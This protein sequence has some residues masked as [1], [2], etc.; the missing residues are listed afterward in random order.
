MN[1][2]SQA[3]PLA[4]LCSVSQAVPEDFSWWDGCI[5]L[6]LQ[7]CLGGWC[8]T[9]HPRFPSKAVHFTDNI[10]VFP[11]SVVA[12]HVCF[13]ISYHSVQIQPCLSKLHSCFWQ[14]GWLHLI[15]TFRFCNY[16]SFLLNLKQF[17]CYCAIFPYWLLPSCYAFFT[18][19]K[20]EMHTISA[21]KRDKK[22]PTN[23]Y[24]CLTEIK[25]TIKHDWHCTYNPYH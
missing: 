1:F 17:S 9:E 7:Q 10:N 20:A 25:Q 12:D 13:S 18:C 16:D 24:Y 15:M 19:W 14:L 21:E 3:N 6:C 2:G 4:T 5:V 22:N 8:M 23:S 11:F